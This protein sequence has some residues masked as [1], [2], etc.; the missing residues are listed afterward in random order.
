MY[1]ITQECYRRRTG[2]PRSYRCR[3]EVERLEDRR[4]L[5]WSM[6]EVCVSDDTVEPTTPD[7]IV[8][9][10]PA[11]ATPPWSI[12]RADA[13][14][15]IESRNLHVS[16]ANLS[17]AGMHLIDPSDGQFEGQVVYLDF[18]GARE[19]T[20]N[21][22]VVIERID[23]PSFQLPKELAGQEAIV[24]DRL[25][26]TMEDTFAG[27]GI[28]FTTL[29]P[30]SGE[31]ST[32]YV[33]GDG[34]A[35]HEYGNFLGLA[36]QI[37]VGNKDRADSALVFSERIVGGSSVVTLPD[38]MVHE[39]G[40][41]LGYGH[42]GDEAGR[43]SDLASVAHQEATHVFITYQAHDLYQALFGVAGVN[44]ELTSFL[45]RPETTSA[46]DG[47]S[48]IE[49]V[50]EEDLPLTAFRFMNH[51]S[52]GGDTSPSGY[53]ELLDGLYDYDSA[54]T[55]ATDRFVHA[56]V[57]YLVQQDPFSAYWWFG[58]GLHLL[59]DS[60]VPAH[61]HN[62]PHAGDP[63]TG[64]DQY[65]VSVTPG[66]DSDYHNYFRFDA[67]NGTS[68]DFQDW[69]NRYW[70]T[71]AGVTILGSSSQALWDR[72]NEYGSLEELFRETTD[73][74]DD[75]DSDDYD[76]D[77]HNG[78]SGDGFPLARLDDLDRSEDPLVHSDWSTA[79]ERDWLRDLEPWEISVLARDVG[80]WA[81][82]Q[83]TL[84]MR[85][86]Y[87]ELGEV[88]SA[89]NNMQIDHTGATSLDLGWDSVAGA[90]GYVVYRSTSPSSNFSRIGISSLPGYSDS[91]LDPG[92][93][94]FYRIYAY[95]DV[96]GL[97]SQ[98]GSAPSQPVPDI[99]GDGDVNCGDANLLSMEIATGG[100]NLAVYDFNDNG[101]I[102]LSDLHEW[103]GLAGEMNLGP[104]LA[105]LP[106]DSDLNGV[107]DGS[108]FNTWNSYKFTGIGGG[109]GGGLW[110]LGDFDANGAVD[111]SDFN[112]WNTHKFT[113][114]MLVTLDFDAASGDLYASGGGRL[115]P[116]LRWI[117]RPASGGRPR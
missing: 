73:Y 74:T 84:F 57:A 111:G 18:D 7:V 68:W 3:P 12:D 113:S 92:S 10:H 29:P 1:T 19:I 95:N 24:I 11:L 72:S 108:D 63:V 51:F 86:F 109:G 13:G 52:E 80:T 91:G 41:L 103:L 39:I 36:E 117:W 46:D 54:Y 82:E 69:V 50:K 60:T 40:H 28:V 65:E 49:G 15:V 59:Q 79:V 110:C 115:Y 89:P 100:G 47:N 97:G 81:V 30:A 112:I 2:Y 96:A 44:L 58:R 20:Y 76:G 33:G 85:Y 43:A 87:D 45:S 42:L 98:Y 37:D 93:L 21:G 106:G 102:E 4:V 23:V 78:I 75:Y 101:Q 104:G 35:F 22:P 16:G 66:V 34:S 114:S 88:L 116:G 9:P 8:A 26:Q 71:P 90:D 83:S 5:A 17:L 107:V 25:L 61:V 55:T 94:Y 67:A 32:V 14:V 56:G 77:Y 105:Y 48:I 70:S 99:N 31:Y 53:D 6:V 38:V 62:D 64:D 27:T